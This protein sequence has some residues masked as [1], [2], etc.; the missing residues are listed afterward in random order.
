MVC[1]KYSTRAC[2]I[3][4]TSETG[5]HSGFQEHKKSPASVVNC[6]T[7][8]K[9]GLVSTILTTI[10]KDFSRLKKNLSKK[11]HHVEKV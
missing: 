6:R 11:I 1:K 7:L 4:G 10:L 3:F 8:I 2:E 5:C 9:D